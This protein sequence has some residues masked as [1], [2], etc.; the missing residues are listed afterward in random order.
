MGDV[1]PEFEIRDLANPPVA[2]QSFREIDPATRSF[3][4]A[5]K[6]ALDLRAASAHRNY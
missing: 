2:Y 4:H 3:G 5:L 6:I 1:P